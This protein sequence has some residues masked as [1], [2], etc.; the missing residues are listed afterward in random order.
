MPDDPRVP[1]A[2]RNGR[3]V[4]LDVGETLVDETRVFSIWADVVGIPRFTLMATLGGT[5]VGGQR[6]WH[7]FFGL[8]GVEDWRAFA[9]HVEERYGGFQ[10]V[11]L[12]PD[13]LR[14]IEGLKAAGYG[15]AVVANQPG[16]RH[17][18]LEALEV[19]VDVMAMS[20]TMGVAKPD[21]AFY[22]RTLELLGDPSPADVAYVGDRIDND[23]VPSAAAGMQSIWIRRGPWGYLQRDETA[24][25]RFE[26]RSLEELVA[27]IGMVWGEIPPT[28]SP[29]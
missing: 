18:Q 21:P 22:A 9:P 27:R 24:A 1:R 10:S 17:A 6:E 23:V 15:V 29:R 5:I 3:W 12:Y 16:S 26:V 19:R 28:V 14:A 13:A 7:G 20:E 25:A 11:D 8:L 4:V 2:P